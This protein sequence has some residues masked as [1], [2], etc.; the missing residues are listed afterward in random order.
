VW[1]RED[2]EPADSTMRLQVRCAGMGMDIIYRCRARDLMALDPAELLGAA[3]GAGEQWD[4]SGAGFAAGSGER[5]PL[6]YSERQEAY[7]RALLNQTYR[8]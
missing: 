1:W 2:F 3:D 5:R 8:P 6:T 4:L 7:E